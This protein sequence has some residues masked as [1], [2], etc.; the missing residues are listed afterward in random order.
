MKN[1]NFQCGGADLGRI[2]VYKLQ[3]FSPDCELLFI[4]V[5]S[6]SHECSI[7]SSGISH[8]GSHLP[9]K[10]NCLLCRVHVFCFGF[11]CGSLL[12]TCKVDFSCKEK[13]EFTFTNVLQKLWF[14][15]L[16]ACI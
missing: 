14:L 12:A 2:C 7:N 5:S 4:L 9:V 13:I 1:M 15:I 16:F 10:L 8:E 6:C 3:T 11:E